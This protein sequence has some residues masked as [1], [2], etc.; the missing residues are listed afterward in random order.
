MAV[1]GPSFQLS[2]RCD[3]S[4][5]KH[6]WEDSQHVCCRSMAELSPGAETQGSFCGTGGPPPATPIGREVS[7]APVALPRP[8]PSG[9]GCGVQLLPARNRDCF[10]C[11]L[12]SCGINSWVTNQLILQPATCGVSVTPC[13][14]SWGHC[15]GWV[16]SEDSIVKLACCHL[17]G[18][19]DLAW[20]R[21]WAWGQGPVGRAMPPVPASRSPSCAALF[22]APSLPCV[23]T[24]FDK[25]QPNHGSCRGCCVLQTVLWG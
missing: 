23:L 16:C 19:P 15:S 18:R 12:A 3:S 13:C 10:F 24:S 20:G 22:L 8:H 7:V 17:P 5:S 11:V 9:A 4:G 2:L 1:L 21:L 25:S 14:C 6:S